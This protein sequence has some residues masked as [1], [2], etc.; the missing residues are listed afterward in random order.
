MVNVLIADDNN[1]FR[2]I[3]KKLLLKKL[4]AT[5]FEATDGIDALTFFQSEELHLTFLDVDMPLMNGVEVLEVIRSNEKGMEL[6]VIIITGQKDKTVFRELFRL[7]ITDYI[8]KGNNIA[9]I[10]KRLLKLYIKNKDYFEKLEFRDNKQSM[11]STT[12]QNKILVVDDDSS[13]VDLLKSNFKKNY[14]ILQVSTGIEALKF[15]ADHFPK[16]IMLGE[17]LRFINEKKVADKVHELSH[18]YESTVSYLVKR[19]Y[20]KNNNYKSF[21]HIIDKTQNQEKLI[22]ELSLVL[23]IPS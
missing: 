9:Q 5:I 2:K 4:K 16:H 23:G 15:F 11:D 21:N 14:E 22:K 1:T 3:L 18:N 7:G 20:N 19:N 12:D 17:N 8:I 6:P 10:G 13:F